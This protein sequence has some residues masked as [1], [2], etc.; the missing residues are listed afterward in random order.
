[1]GILALR[2]IYGPKFKI[3][4]KFKDSDLNLRELKNLCLP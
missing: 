2:L 1:M 4:N 3:N